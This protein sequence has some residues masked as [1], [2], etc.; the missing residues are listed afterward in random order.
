MAEQAVL[1]PEERASHPLPAAHCPLPCSPFA[2]LCP[3]PSGHGR[4]AHGKGEAK[5][6][7][8]RSPPAVQKRWWPLCVPSTLARGGGPGA[9]FPMQ[10]KQGQLG[11]KLGRA[12][13]PRSGRGR[14]SARKA[15][16]EAGLLLLA[17]FP[18][19]GIQRTVHMWVPPRRSPWS[20]CEPGSTP[21][22]PCTP[23]SLLGTLT[24]EPRASDGP[25]GS[26]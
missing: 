22:T 2:L 8:Q 26:P 10:S 21:G 6:F 14:P 12:A 3:L 15:S 16:W 19:T 13:L 18:L 23:S 17:G 9:T 25:A 24:Q 4:P 5:R 20:M 11:P 1:P 7:T